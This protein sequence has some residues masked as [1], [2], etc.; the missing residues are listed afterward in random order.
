MTRVKTGLEVLREEQV[1]HV[2]GKKTAIILNPS[3]VN[4]QLEHALHLLADHTDIELVAAFG[5]QHGVQGETQDNM[6]EW[7]DYRDPVTQLP[8]Y[9]LYGKTLSPTEKMLANVEVLLFDVQDIGARYYTYIHTMALAMEACRKQGRS[10]I[11]LDR[12]NPING[13]DVQ[14]NVLH[15]NF[16][17]F[18]GL[19]PLAVRHGMTTGELALCFNDHFGIGCE[20]HIVKMRGWEREMFFEDT[21][22]PWILPS[23][24]IP[25]VD[26]AV[27]YPGMCLLEGTNVSEG[28]G[29]TRPFELSGAPWIEP[30]RM[31]KRL[32]DIDLPGVVFRPVHFTPTFHKWSHQMIGGVQIHVSDR[33][34]FSPFLTGLALI[35]VYREL[36]EDQFQWK[37]PPYEYEYEKLPFDILCGTDQIRKQIEAGL[38][39]TEMQESWAVELQK[40]RELREQYLLY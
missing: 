16:S 13:V 11:V 6:I 33:R 27:V 37:L 2:R 20:L 34:K 10:F 39:L 7:Q 25:T 29:T 31:V 19:Y 40:F 17:S 36:G 4:R 1:E 30:H 9:S 5:P 18:V 28:R 15:P 21:H 23:P 32:R 26:T 35:T 8:V 38:N 12:P 22:L 3:S 14:G 24:N